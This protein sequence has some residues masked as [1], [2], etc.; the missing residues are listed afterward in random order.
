MS[1]ANGRPY[2]PKNMSFEGI[3][4][5]WGRRLMIDHGFS[6]ATVRTPVAHAFNKHF[7]RY[8]I[9]LEQSDQQ[10]DE[11]VV[12]RKCSEI[13]MRMEKKYALGTQFDKRFDAV[14]MVE[15]VLESEAMALPTEAPSGQLVTHVA[16]VVPTQTLSI[17]EI[18]FLKVSFA[19]NYDVEAQSVTCQIFFSEYDP[20]S[21]VVQNG[22]RRAPLSMIYHLKEVM[23]DAWSNNVDLQEIEKDFKDDLDEAAK[24]RREQDRHELTQRRKS[25]LYG[26]AI[27]GLLFVVAVRIYAQLSGVDINFDDYVKI[28]ALSVLGGAVFFYL[29]E[30]FF[31][32]E[33]AL[34]SGNEPDEIA[35]STQGDNGQNKEKQGE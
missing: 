22:V 3:K 28:F 15:A 17:R 32:E 35:D 4:T 7:R 31:S 26:Y 21:P 14:K 10:P 19:G 1:K 33:E 11:T 8:I 9:E 2:R 12:L 24:D 18:D 20:S 23:G 25:K 5:V 6:G 30:R 16:C 29:K 34:G 27:I 13:M